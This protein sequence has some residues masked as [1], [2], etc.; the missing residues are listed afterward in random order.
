MTIA[1]WLIIIGLAIYLPTD[2][3]LWLTGRQ[4]ISQR[5]WAWSKITPI[6]PFLLGVL[7]G[8]LITWAW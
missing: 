1:S 5:F 2:L 7:V 8:H 6:P 3:V 4:T